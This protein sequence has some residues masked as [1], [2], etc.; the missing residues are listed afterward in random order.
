MT[1][2][3]VINRFQQVADVF[4]CIPWYKKTSS[5]HQLNI[6]QFLRQIDIRSTAMIYVIS[7]LSFCNVLHSQVLLRVYR[8][9]YRNEVVPCTYTRDVCNC[10]VF[11]RMSAFVAVC[12]SLC[13]PRWNATHIASEIY[14]CISIISL[15]P[16]FPIHEYDI[17]IDWRVFIYFCCNE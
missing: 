5:R 3:P 8:M 6:R 2:S 17:P 15:L 9:V 4:I 14:R 11:V 10:L 13:A 1:G 16:K 7:R 12:V